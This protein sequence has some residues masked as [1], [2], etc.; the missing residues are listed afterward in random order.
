MAI[1]FPLKMHG[2]DVRNLEDLR[3]NFDSGAAIKY[4]KDGRLIKWLKAR[5]H[6]DTAEKI[7][8]LDDT[9]SDFPQKLC[10]ALGVDDKIL[11]AFAK[12]FGT[13]NVWNIAD[14]VD[15]PPPEHKK[16]FIDTF[17]GE[18]YSERDLLIMV[19]NYSLRGFAVTRD[20][21]CVV[22]NFNPSQYF[23]QKFLYDKIAA[24][25]SSGGELKI[26]DV[27]GRDWIIEFQQLDDTFAERLANFLNAVRS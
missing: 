16:N 24:V 9:A 5:Y 23:R 10:A 13:F 18:E 11:V 25:E 20:A 17:C 21:F 12:F 22:Y 1:K 3:E 27:D 14:I 2:V 7:S 8:A 26:V 4:F 6:D 15:E 19:V